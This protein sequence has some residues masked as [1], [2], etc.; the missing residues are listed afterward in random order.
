MGKSDD[1]W[2]RFLKM[3]TLHDPNLSVFLSDASVKKVIEKKDFEV[4][5]GKSGHLY[6]KINCGYL[7]RS[8]VLKHI[9]RS[10]AILLGYGKCNACIKEYNNITLL[11]GLCVPLLFLMVYLA[12]LS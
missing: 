1:I 4:Y 9:K 6:H 10:D 11:W 12:F 5:M 3:K 2:K 7:S 8:R